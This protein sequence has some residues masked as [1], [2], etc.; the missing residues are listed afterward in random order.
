MRVDPASSGLTLCRPPPC[1]HHGQVIQD[2]SCFTTHSCYATTAEPQ[3]HVIGH[4]TLSVTRVRN[5][6]ALTPCSFPAK[7]IQ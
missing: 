5:Q 4:S 2:P 1:R 7:P 3:S 6:G